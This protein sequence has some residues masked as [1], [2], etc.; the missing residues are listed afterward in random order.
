M[1]IPGTGFSGYFPVFVPVTR[2]LETG[3]SAGWPGMPPGSGRDDIRI[4]GGR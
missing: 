1:P 2:R 4:Q 3:A